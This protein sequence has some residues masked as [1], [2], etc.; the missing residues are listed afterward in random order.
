MADVLIKS[1][2]DR[3]MIVRLFRAENEMLQCWFLV[4][5]LMEC[6]SRRSLPP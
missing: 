2:R 4:G 1:N 6:F 5:F 3:E